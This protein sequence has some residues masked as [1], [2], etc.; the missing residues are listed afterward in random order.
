MYSLSIT[1]DGQVIYEGK[2]AVR[3]S[4]V[5]RAKI[6]RDA[7]DALVEEFRRAKYFELQDHYPVRNMFVDDV[8]S[9]ITSIR[10]GNRFKRVDNL[11]YG[12]ESLRDLEDRIDLV[13][14]SGQW[15]RVDAPTLRELQRQGWNPD[16]PEGQVYFV[17]AVVHSDVETVAEFIRA[18]TSVK[19]PSLLAYAHTSEMLNLL[20]RSGCPINGVAYGETPLMI[21]AR[22]PTP[23]RVARLL[24]AGANVNA[25][26]ASGRT[27]LMTAAEEGSPEV[28]NLLVRAKADVNANNG[29]I[30]R[31]A[32]LMSAVWGLHPENMR[33]LLEAGADVNAV[34]AGGLDG[35]VPRFQLAAHR[36]G[37][38]DP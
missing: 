27:V 34:D 6:S 38:A 28:V 8:S 23:E 26:T 32:A 4:G 5:V 35:P 22:W 3:V 13:A 12:P 24:A 29:E 7:M 2:Q 37:K 20:L 19:D 31:A 11:I 21:V 25:A 1:G 10:V 15:T 33:L 30:G 9:T 16:S 14:G 18:G 36:D 17:E